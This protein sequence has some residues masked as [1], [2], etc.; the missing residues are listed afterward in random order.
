MT[1]QSDMLAAA[2][3]YAAQGWRVFPCHTPAVGPTTTCSC[4]R[5]DCGQIGK[6]PRTLKGLT[7]AS[8][9]PAQITKWWTT[10]PDANIA[11]LPGSAGLCAFDLDTDQAIATARALGLFA[12]PTFEVRTGNGVHRYYQAPP[13]PNGAQIRGIVVRSMHGYVMLPPSLHASGR[14]YEVADATPA[15]PLPPLVV[16]EAQKATSREGSRERVTIAT[17]SATI[18]AGGRHDALMAL[19]GSLA[20]RGVPLE[21]GGPLVHDANVA[22][23]QPPKSA[24]EVQRLIEYAYEQE[25]QSFTAPARHLVLAT[26]SPVSSQPQRSVNPFDAPLPGML[27]AVAQY[28]MATAAHPVRLYAV[29]AALALGST[30]CARRYTTMSANYSTLYFLVVGRS[31]SGKEHTR[32]VV[33]SVLRS[34]DAASLIGPNEWTS[35]S[36]VWSSVYQQPQSVAIL[37][38]IGQFLGAATGG[39]DGASM[40]NGVLTALMELYG[41]VDDTAITPQFSTL[42]LTDKQ[43]K[44]AERKQIERPAL[45]VVGLTTP[46]E[47]YDSLKSNRISSGFL[48]R[49]LVME[50]DAGLGDL[51]EHGAAVDVP[52]AVSEWVRQLLTPQSTLDT[53]QRPANIP[54]ARALSISGDAFALFTQFKRECNRRADRLVADRLGELPVRAN[55]QAMRL[56][57]I[58]AL[59]RDPA[60]VAVEL[61]DAEWAVQCVS[62]LLGLLIEKVQ[63]RLSDSPIH[64]LRNRLLT[65]LR[66]AGAK[67]LTLREMMRGPVFRGV[68]K[69][70]RDETI[71]WAQE[72]GH[73]GWS[74]IPQ[75]GPG[76]PRQALCILAIPSTAEAA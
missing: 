76:R 42:T 27:E 23:C 15:I 5:P 9:D 1:T 57:L 45:S 17:Q 13:F 73:A 28:A 43:R 36:A 59:A 55:E 52:A 58:A 63:E 19:A 2:L 48:N 61:L 8:S 22:R 62:Y 64:A 49:F 51:G 69:R 30:V 72:A 35:R 65:Q 31:G 16:D 6:H 39:S 14:R 25:R 24:E 56:A 32:R 40:K 41:R 66:E 70:N 20:A 38:E 21:I 47:W 60:A 26:A 50:S 37:D 33:H 67:G 74:D 53:L 7:D 34:A 44:A 3:D 11:G 29:A 71:Q 10:W 75:D 4:R 46:D 54:A 68:D 18:T 12:E